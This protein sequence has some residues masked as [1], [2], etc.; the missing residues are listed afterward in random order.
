[1][2][3]REKTIPDWSILLALRNGFLCAE[4]R[5][6][7]L[8]CHEED[9]EL[10]RLLRD[11][12]NLSDRGLVPE[13]LRP[14]GFTTGCCEVVECCTEDRTL[15]ELCTKSTLARLDGSEVAEVPRFQ[16]LFERF[17]VS[18]EILG[19]CGSDSSPSDRDFLPFARRDPLGE[20]QFPRV[21]LLQRRATRGFLVTICDVDED[22]FE[23]SKSLLLRSLLISCASLLDF[24]F[25]LFGRA[26]RCAPVV[27][28]SMPLICNRM[29]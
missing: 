7:P 21:V 5:E 20:T 9:R 8:D 28:F 22:F 27:C 19:G 2:C 17:V 29:S 18:D 16:E 25:S 1:M 13:L 24:D 26:V 12:D 10:F 15:F 6:E 3:L 4:S 23:D 14:A 11:L